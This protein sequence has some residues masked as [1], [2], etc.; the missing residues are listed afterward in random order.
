MKGVRF[1]RA[2]SPYSAGDTA[3]LPDDVAERLIAAGEAE[4]YRFPANPHGAE[5]SLPRQT[6][7]T[8]GAAS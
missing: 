8:K 4:K 2:M 7:I 6:Y 5:P 1:N 3:L